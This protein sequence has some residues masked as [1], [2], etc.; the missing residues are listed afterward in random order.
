VKTLVAFLLGMVAM[1]CLQGKADTWI[2]VS[3][4]AK[5]LDGG[6]HCN[7][8]TTG[9][10]YERTQIGNDRTQIGYS[11]GFYRNSNC[12]WSFYAAR[13]WL[14]LSLQVSDWRLRAGGIAGGVTGY[15]SAVLPVAGL[16]ASVERERSS[17]R[18][19]RTAATWSG[20]R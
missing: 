18:R 12:A 4:L 5:H 9:L 13:S 7:S 11:F 14:P 15:T 17:C 20:S 1:V 6:E 16:A 19:S 2:V 3:G 10:G 8:I